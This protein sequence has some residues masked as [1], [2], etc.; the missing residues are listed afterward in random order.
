[1][2]VIPPEVKERLLQEVRREYPYE[3][4][5]ILAGKGR[6]VKH[7]YP[8]TNTEK[9]SVSYFMDP[10][11]QLKVMKDMR[12]RGMEM[13][14]IYHSH[15][16]TSAYP[17]SRDIE[18]AFYPVSYVIISLENKENPQIRSFR[19]QEDKVEEEEVVFQED[20]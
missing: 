16:F 6:V 17:S 9:S 14:G 1:M 12:K 20:E 8:M 7:V 5:G 3:A 19:I 4:C 15:P 18:L 11:E 13:V 2:I 10:K